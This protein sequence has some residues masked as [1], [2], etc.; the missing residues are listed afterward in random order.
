MSE[1]MTEIIAVGLIPLCVLILYIRSIIVR[2]RERKQ[3]EM[4]Q[5]I[6]K[7]KLKDPEFVKQAKNE[8]FKNVEYE[9]R[10]QK[11]LPVRCYNCK[12][13]IDSYAW[14][15]INSISNQQ[16]DSAVSIGSYTQINVKEQ[17]TNRWKCPKCGYEF[18]A[19]ER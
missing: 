14:I 11:N 7:E 9:N 12:E 3:Q 13:R 4:E 15:K 16:F 10:I 5:E 8:F 1:L 18:E 2:E 17:V 19:T 6:L